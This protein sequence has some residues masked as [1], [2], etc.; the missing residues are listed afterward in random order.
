MAKKDNEKVGQTKL[1][2]GERKAKTTADF[3]AEKQ[4]AISIS[5]FFTKNRHLLGFDNPRKALLTAVKEA[6]DN[7]IDATEE[8]KVLPEIKVFVEDTT[9]ER[10]KITVE[11]NGPGIVKAQ[12]PNIFAKLLYGSKFHHLK[13]SLTE[14]EP[15]LIKRN[16]KVELL[17]IG[18]F[19]DSFLKNPDEIKQISKENIFVPA[20]N[21]KDNKY[22]LKKV[23]HVIRHKRANEILKIKT[24]YN[25]EIKVTGCHSLF[26]FNNGKVESIEARNLNEGSFIVVPNKLPEIEDLKEINILDCIELKD[27]QKNW[28]YVYGINEDI[29]ETIK[30]NSK[31]VHKKTDKSRKYYQYP[32]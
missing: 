7:S 27:I 19:V 23:S 22:Y 25:K 4:Q 24:E 14:D 3:L 8:M 9:P 16:G 28:M 12:I 1:V 29:F 17:P 32:F 15:I 10:Y 6:V 21:P 18:E 11:D 20:F 30:K 2:D 13:Q 5:E 31:M 26:A